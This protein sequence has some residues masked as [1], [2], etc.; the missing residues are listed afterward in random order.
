MRVV[1]LAGGVGGAKLAHGLYRA[2]GPDALTVVVNTGDDFDLYGL[3]I[4]PDADTV[5]YTLA[6]LANPETGWGVAGDTWSALDMLGRYG[7]ETWFRLGDRDFATHILR[8]QRL[9]DGW[10]P[11]RVLGALADALGVRAALLPM[12]DEPVATIVQTAAGDLAFQD[13]FV[14]RHHADAITGV[15]F[16][17]IERAAVPEGV[18]L[19]LAEADLIVFC[20]SN[21]IVSIGPILAVPGMRDLLRRAAAP[22]VAVSPI[23]SGKALRGP[24]DAMLLALGYE[25]SPLAVARLYAD[26]LDGM[27]MDRQDAAQAPAIEALPVRV[28]LED[29]I[30]G[31]V[32]ARERLARAVLEFAGAPRAAARP[33]GR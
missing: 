15:R 7:A 23:V 27:V 16:A 32:E 1:A 11:T 22:R 28:A 12:C 10:T 20:P 8:T 29:T 31:D 30:M 5:L 21:P 6:G 17:G 18:R 13:Y 25:S 24:A 4:M 2:L 19:A 14:R 3:R 9:R 26:V 33:A